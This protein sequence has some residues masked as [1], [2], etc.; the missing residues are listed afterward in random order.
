MSAPRPDDARG[1]EVYG[2]VRLRRCVLCSLT[3][4][5]CQEL[6]IWMELVGLLLGGGTRW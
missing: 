5:R 3:I 1:K 6:C 4:R 2:A